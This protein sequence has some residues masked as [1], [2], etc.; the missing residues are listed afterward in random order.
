MQVVKYI[1]ENMD[2]STNTLVITN[3]ELAEKS[4][5]SLDTVSKT[6]ATLKRLR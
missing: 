6:I 2:K 1:L 4:K 5:V 3:R